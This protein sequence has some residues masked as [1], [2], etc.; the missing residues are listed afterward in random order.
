MQDLQVDG[1]VNYHH[2]PKCD[3]QDSQDFAEPCPF[4]QE[5]LRDDFIL[6]FQKHT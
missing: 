6:D 1:D 2:V 4:M 5:L 3:T